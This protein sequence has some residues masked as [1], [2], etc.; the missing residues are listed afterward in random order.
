MVKDQE[1]QIMVARTAGTV[2]VLIF[3]SIALYLGLNRFDRYMHAQ[4]VFQCGMTSRFEQNV[5]EKTMVSY[6]ITDVYKQCLKDAEVT[7]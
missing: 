7:K 1:Y 2:L 3:L 6:P 5:D 4:S